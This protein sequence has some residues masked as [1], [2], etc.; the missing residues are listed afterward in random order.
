MAPKLPPFIV[1]DAK[2]IFPNFSG[3]PTT[4]NVNGGVRTFN[5]VLDLET[6]QKMKNDGWNVKLPDPPTTDDDDEI[7]KDPHIQVRL[8]FDKRPP[9]IVMITSKGR[10]TLTEDTVDVLD[11]VDFETVDLIANA[12]YWEVNGK[13]GFKAYLKSM[14]VTIEEDYLERKYAIK[15]SA[16]G[17]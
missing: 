6:A 4:Y 5:V 8:R 13:Y 11:S 15:D 3:R 1:E 12:S 9:H 10:T 16:Q 14:F 2:I 7:V 17:E